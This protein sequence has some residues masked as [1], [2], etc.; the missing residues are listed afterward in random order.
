MA[1]GLNCPSGVFT[2]IHVGEQD[3]MP[4]VQCPHVPG[5]SWNTVVRPGPVVEVICET[6]AAVNA[7]LIV[8]TTDGRNG[9]LDVLRGSHSERILAIAPCPLLAIPAGS[10][11][12]SVV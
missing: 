3:A 2:L 6:A 11:I 1:T 4:V 10:F 7:G 5:W 9:F 12:A 8:L